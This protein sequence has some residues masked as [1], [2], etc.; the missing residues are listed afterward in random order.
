MNARREIIY[1]DHASTTRPAPEVIASMQEIQE[2]N[3][4]N[5]SSIHSSGQK[6]KVKMEQAR[7][8]IAQY[9][10]AKPGEIIFTSGGTESDNLALIGAAMAGRKRG[11]RIVS[12]PVEHPAVLNTLSYLSR[13]GFEID[14]LDIDCTGKWSPEQLVAL[15][16]KNTILVSVMMANNETGQIFD[17]QTIQNICHENEVVFH[18]DA[19]Q[20]LGKINF[21][22]GEQGPSLLS[23]S[24]HKIYGPKGIGVLYVRSGVEIENQ[25]YGGTQETSLRPGTENLS[26]IAGFAAAIRLLQA[27]PA[28]NEKIRKLRDLF[29]ESL[30]QVLP[31]AEINCNVSERLFSH[32][33]VYFPEVNGDVM[34]LGLDMAGIAVSA[35]SA[36]SSGAN[37][38]SHVLMAMGFDQARVKNSIRFSFGRENTEAEIRITIDEIYKIHER[39]RKIK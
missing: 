12:T 11:N 36:C 15:I 1:L 19:V 29:E 34:L 4:G 31:G 14:Y 2:N 3:W 6:S 13:M 10:G 38:P 26:G 39:V 22:V 9:I 21:K 5:P 7:A 33:N 27:D 30:I 8:V 20:A 18:T 25:L 35:G 24:G 32:S 23:L 17:W 28:E 37:R 16:R